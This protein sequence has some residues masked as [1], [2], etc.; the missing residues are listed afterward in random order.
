MRYAGSAGGGFC[1]PDV[2]IA[3]VENEIARWLKRGAVLEQIYFNEPAPNSKSILQAELVPDPR[4]GYAI[5]YS[6][7]PMAMR[8]ALKA[9]AR[10]H[11]GPGAL[12]IAKQVMT[13]HS[14]EDL[15]AVMERHPES[16][17]EFSVFS[18]L[19]GNLPR[20]NSIIWEV[21]NY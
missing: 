13:L 8:E 17:I 5:H 4:F 10:N 6:T 16:A 1:T 2:P 11:C 20:R 12:L 19:C 15:R 18:V 9:D 21:R 3:E 7:A 14:F